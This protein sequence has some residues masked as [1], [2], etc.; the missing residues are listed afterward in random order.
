[1]SLIMC[2]NSS[3]VRT[4]TTTSSTYWCIIPS[5]RP[6]R[7]AV[8]FSLWAYSSALVGCFCDGFCILCCSRLA[9]VQ[10]HFPALHCRHI[11]LPCT[12]CTARHVFLHCACFP[13]CPA[14]HHRSSALHCFPPHCTALPHVLIVDTVRL[15]RSARCSSAGLQ[16]PPKSVTQ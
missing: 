14:S 8:I 10:T 13:F 1:M 2:C 16:P 12:S 11:F 15:D 5:L 3:G 7:S 4:R 9:Q 6:I